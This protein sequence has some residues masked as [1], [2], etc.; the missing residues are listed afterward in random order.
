MSSKN[1]KASQRRAAKAKQR[2]RKIKR[3]Q[4]SRRNNVH[5]YD[6]E[7]FNFT[8]EEVIRRA[9]LIAD[10]KAKSKGDELTNE[11]ILKGLREATNIIVPVHGAVE[12]L[13]RLASEDKV[14]IEHK[15]EVVNEFDESVVKFVEDI[16]A[17]T[18]LI[19][20]GH[21]PEDYIELIVGNTTLLAKMFEEDIPALM[22]ELLKPYQEI[23]EL[24][25][26]EYKLEGES[27]IEFS[28]RMHNERCVVVSPLYKTEI[29][30]LSE[31]LTIPDVEGCGPTEC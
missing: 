19:S 11:G 14:N 18:T 16:N 29:E 30:D 8:P 4:A 20:K 28:A 23:I 1:T 13:H 7:N 22:E 25:V 21:Q 10:G 2:Q 12:V 5:L 17:I 31:P 24:G 26:K 9:Q 3:A 27:D 6:S 15:A